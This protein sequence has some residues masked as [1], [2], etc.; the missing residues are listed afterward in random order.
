[1][2]W[3]G[4]NPDGG[5]YVPAPPDLYAPLAARPEW[6]PAGNNLS[7]RQLARENTKHPGLFHHWAVLPGLPSC[8]ASPLMHL[9]SLDLLLFK[10]YDE[11][12]LAL[13]R[14]VNCF[15]GPNGSGK[16]NLLDAIHYLALT[17]SAFSPTDGLSIQH[18]ADYA[19]VRGRF[20]RND[21][22]PLPGAGALSAEIVQVNLHTAQK[23]TVLLNKAP[24]ERLAEHIG[25]FPV[26][27][28]SP[29]DTDL[30]R[31]GSEER[32][33]FF[34]G[35]LSQL[36]APYLDTLLR[37]NQVLRQRNALLKHFG[38]RRTFDRELLAVLDDQLVPLGSALTEARSRFL[39][40][41]ELLFQRHYAHLTDGAESVAL[42]YRSQL[43]DT[44]FAQL[45]ADHQRRD[46]AAERS[47]VGPHRDDFEFLLL[48]PPIGYDQTP[49]PVRQLA[50]QGQQKSF[51]IAL[52]LAQFELL[53]ARHHT[54]PL[55]LL[56][57]IFDRLDERRIQRLLTL[58]ADGT[59]GQVFLT[60]S[61]P[62]RAAALLRPLTS[63]MAEFRVENGRVTAAPVPA[64]A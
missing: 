21:E 56:D 63:E 39:I 51:V 41:F 25:R 33:R 29:Y 53:A 4:V 55:L 62:H 15:T 16:T 40:S 9:E 6:H 12:H 60:D 3:F 38:E 50:S 61:H 13:A 11:A 58:V 28:L 18:G 23:K 57:D 7:E 52:K 24:Y 22:P 30:V 17:K 42:T 2:I 5:S 48:P 37:Y 43:L 32:R 36:D 49:R 8:P 19:M 26:V 59:F 54:R 47:T 31:E 45:L 35:L 34:D 27:L 64:R 10:N 44:D 14:R 1:M 46:L 20:Q